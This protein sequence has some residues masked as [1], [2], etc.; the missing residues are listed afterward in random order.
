MNKDS[1]FTHQDTL[2]GLNQS[3]PLSD[4]LRFIH[5]TITQRFD[6]IERIAVAVYDAK[7]E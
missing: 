4:K 3:G 5:H 6:F 7:N 2:S 1:L